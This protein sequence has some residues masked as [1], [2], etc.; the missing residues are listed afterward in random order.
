MTRLHPRDGGYSFFSDE[1]YELAVNVGDIRRC[2]KCNQDLP[3]EA[4]SNT[5]GGNYLRPEC[6]K[7]N[8]RLFRDRNRLKAKYGMPP[9]GYHC[10]ICELSESDV[11]GLGGSKNGAWVIDHNHDTGGFRGWLC[12][13]CNRTL[14]GFNDD[15]ANLTRAICYL[16]DMPIEKADFILFTI[17]KLKGETPFDGEISSMVLSPESQEE[18]NGYCTTD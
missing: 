6:K 9:E 2:S 14:G 11:M 15:P 16:L 18:Q 13:R 8:T 7:C 5:S 4:F 1:E 3:K 10:P 17:N 12:H